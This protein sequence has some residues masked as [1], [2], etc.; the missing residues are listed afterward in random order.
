MKG[1]T[2]HRVPV[3]PD[4]AYDLASLTKAAQTATLTM[5][6]ID[7][8]L[9]AL[10]A[11]VGDL[12][13]GPPPGLRGLRVLDL[14]AHRSGLPPWR[15]FYLDPR[16]KDPERLA[17]AILSEPPLCPI[18]RR[19]VYSDLNFLLLG[20]ILEKAWGRP[21]PELFAELAARPLGLS[22]TGHDGR[23]LSAAPTEDG[24]RIG[25]PLG[26]PEAP[27]LGLVPTGRVHDD[28]AAFL[29]GA[30]GHAGLFGTAPELFKLVRSWA[31]SLEG[32]GEGG[33]PPLA[34]A[35]TI[36]EMLRRRPTAEDEGRPAGFD[37]GS[38]LMAG[39]AGH[40][41]YTGGAL[42]WDPEGDRAMV[43]LC[44]RV[45]PTARNQ[46]IGPFRESLYAA[47]RKEWR[48]RGF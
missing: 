11:A 2:R 16:N 25:G 26:S 9:V 18:G 13:L 5:L 22:A 24:P 39:F 32:R 36:S 45:H 3:G 1:L 17:G 19:T 8:G 44:N 28:N 21:L 20:L 38:G 35:A 46:R 43:F 37:A 33:L 14:L 31:L 47:L 42:W 41:G 27:A 12:G 23:G 15:P 4:T 30:A 29:G 7:R 34:G 6:A 10:E 48:E 40:L